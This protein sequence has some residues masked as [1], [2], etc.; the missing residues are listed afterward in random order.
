MSGQVNTPTSPVSSPNNIIEQRNGLTPQKLYIYNTYTHP[1]SHER[2]EINWNG[3]SCQI[4]T[5]KDGAGVARPLYL[6]AAD[7]LYLGNGGG[8]QWAIA[9]GGTFLTLADNI[10]D[11]GA[12]GAN[13][14][15]NLYLAG[16]ATLGADPTQPLEATTKQ[17]VDARDATHDSAIAALQTQVANLIQRVNILSS[18]VTWPGPQAGV[19][20]HLKNK[21]GDCVSAIIYEDATKRANADTIS[22]VY[23]DPDYPGDWSFRQDVRED[24][25][26]DLPFNSW[27][28]P[29]YAFVA[30]GPVMLRRRSA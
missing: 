21:D 28:V 23:V 20:V 22:V 7:N 25:G 27:H 14:P 12:S 10:Y 15:R 18:Q 17:Y 30:E 1:A 29:E 3:L 5:M 26:P 19:V 16:A 11:I 9:G 13:R 6:V 8:S 24:T 2:L 4:Q